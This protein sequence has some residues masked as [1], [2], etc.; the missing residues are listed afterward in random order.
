MPLKHGRSDK[1][2]SEN[3]AKLVR[4]GRDPQQA[5]AI[6]YS[7]QRRAENRH[8]ASQHTQASRRFHKSRVGG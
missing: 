8:N 2:R 3:I 7:E 4:E 5:V 1:T 6:A